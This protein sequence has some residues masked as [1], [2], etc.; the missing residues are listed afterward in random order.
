MWLAVAP[1]FFS[2]SEN[3]WYY[4]TGIVCLIMAIRGLMIYN[5]LPEKDN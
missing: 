2:F 4:I 3:P 1:D 5:R